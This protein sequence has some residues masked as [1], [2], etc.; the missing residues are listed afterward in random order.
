MK[1]L[2]IL[3]ALAITAQAGEQNLFN[4]KDLTGWVGNS[5]FWSVEDGTITGTTTAANPTKGNTFLIWN[6]GEPSDFTLTLKY[7]MSPGDE[8]AFTN[9]GIQYRSRIIDPEK[10][11]VGGY[12]AD[13]EYGEKF[14]GILYEEKGRGILA[15]RGQEVA[16]TQGD[17]PAKPKIE[18]TG[19]TG[20]SKE[21]QAAIEKDG[22]NEYRIV[23]EGN[24]VQH[25]INGKLTVDVT[26]NTAEAPTKGVIALQLHAGPPM[27]I[28]F[29]NLLLTTK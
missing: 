29:K 6:D 16:I 25:F 23:A 2:S 9:S 4:G 13:L 15:Q 11:V 12:Q 8:K 17:A 1:T 14:S 28:Q 20:D 7:K 24:H 19:E 18:V 10:F 5:N 22:W 26:D 21:I 3:A 27:K